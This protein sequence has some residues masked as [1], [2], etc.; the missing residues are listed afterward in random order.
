MRLNQIFDTVAVSCD[1]KEDVPPQDKP[2]DSNLIDDKTCDKNEEYIPPHDK[3]IYPNLIDDKTGVNKLLEHIFLKRHISKNVTALNNLNIKTVGD[4]A[5]LNH[6]NVVRLPVIC[7]K[8]VSVRNA[9]KIYENDKCKKETKSKFHL[10]LIDGIEPLDN[11]DNMSDK[12][13]QINEILRIIKSRS[14]LDVEGIANM[15][16]DNVSMKTKKKKKECV[17][18]D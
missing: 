3:P 8:A 11:D 9:L 16:S 4:L 14:D 7:S 18:C 13:L 15:L 12:E 6:V 17:K 5:R 2:I 1:V 10:Q